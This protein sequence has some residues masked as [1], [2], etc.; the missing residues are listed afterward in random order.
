MNIVNVFESKLYQ[1]D[2]EFDSEESQEEYY[3]CDFWIDSDYILVN[4]KSFNAVQ[5][6]DEVIINLN[7][8]ND[9]GILDIEL[10]NKQKQAIMNFY[11][12]KQFKLDNASGKI[13]ELSTQTMDIEKSDEKMNNASLAIKYR[14]GQG[15]NYGWWVLVS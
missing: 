8:L 3:N 13:K 15:Y 14:G 2:K 10:T 4:G 1:N 7:D 11:D 12:N 5:V 6:D 9:A